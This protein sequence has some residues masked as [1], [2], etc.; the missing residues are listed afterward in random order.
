[1]TV[2]VF[3]EGLASINGITINN[4]KCL[5]IFM[6]IMENLFIFCLLEM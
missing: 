1:M 2:D 3:L 4:K 5:S 6:I